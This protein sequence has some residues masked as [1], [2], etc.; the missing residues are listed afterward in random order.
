LNTAACS[1]FSTAAGRERREP[2]EL[3]PRSTAS[4]SA[5]PCAAGEVELSQG[6]PLATSANRLPQ[7]RAPPSVEG[8]TSPTPCSTLAPQAPAASEIWG[9]SETSLLL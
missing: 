7:R 6:H 1:A 5:A 8:R 9:V 4:N 2:G 3:D